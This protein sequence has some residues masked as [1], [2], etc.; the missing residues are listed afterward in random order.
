MRDLFVPC[1]RHRRLFRFVS[2]EFVAH[3]PRNLAYGLAPSGSVQAL[4]NNA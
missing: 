1:Q 4:F 3:L 2:D